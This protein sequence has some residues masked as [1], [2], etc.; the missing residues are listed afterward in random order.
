MSQG[1]QKYL[2]NDQRVHKRRQKPFQS[3]WSEMAFF[4]KIGHFLYHQAA[5]WKCRSVLNSWT[6]CK[7]TDLR[8]R[9]GWVSLFWCS[10]QICVNKQKCSKNRQ[11]PATLRRMKQ[12]RKVFIFSGVLKVTRQWKIEISS[13]SNFFTIYER[14]KFNS[15]FLW[16]LRHCVSTSFWLFLQQFVTFF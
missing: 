3:S 11:N 6:S 15:D 14:R 5:V 16:F 10:C 7:M 8:T 4:V 2:W 12:S 13:F 9:E 1:F